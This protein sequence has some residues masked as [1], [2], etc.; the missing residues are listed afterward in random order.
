MQGNQQ[1]WLIQMR[2]LLHH[3]VPRFIKHI[4]DRGGV[5][6]AE[7]EWLKRE[8]ESP[9]CMS[10]ILAKADEYLLFPKNKKIFDQGLF[11]LVRALAIMSFIPGGVRIMGLHFCSEIED[12]IEVEDGCSET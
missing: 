7:R 6:D 4:L 8:D 2:S 9:D 12:F 11:V 1:Q 10:G 5:S 3:N